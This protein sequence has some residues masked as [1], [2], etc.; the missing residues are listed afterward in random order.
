M[1]RG[2][3]TEWVYRKVRNGGK[4]YMNSTTKLL[5]SS[6]HVR[7]VNDI[8]K[9][10]NQALGAFY[11]VGDIYHDP[12]TFGLDS[13][14]KNLYGDNL[15]TAWRELLEFLFVKPNTWQLE[16][17]HFF[18]FDGII[19][20]VPVRGAFPEMTLGVMADLTTAF[21]TETREVLFEDEF[22]GMEDK[23]VHF[24][25]YL[26]WGDNIDFDHMDPLVTEAFFKVSRDLS[27]KKTPSS[28]SGKHLIDCMVK[29]PDQIADSVG[30][31]LTTDMIEITPKLIATLTKE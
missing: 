24:A 18:D 11:V 6:Q 26:N 7:T 27:V 23:Y 20:V 4:R 10:L 16:V 29:S 13:L 21:V 15:K 5:E 9:F 22:K 12:M 28:I 14:T 31:E 30:I 3:K 1:A 8:T 2:A 25:Y 19:E 17:F